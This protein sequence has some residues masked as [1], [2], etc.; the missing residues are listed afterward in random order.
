MLRSNAGKKLVESQLDDWTSEVSTWSMALSL[1]Q[2]EPRNLACLA[3]W[4][5]NGESPRGSYISTHQVHL[6][7]GITGNAP[8]PE[9]ETKL[10]H[11]QE[12]MQLPTH[13]MIWC[14]LFKAT[15]V[16]PASYG[17]VKAPG[18]AAQNATGIKVYIHQAPIIQ[19]QIL[20]ATQAGSTPKSEINSGP[21]RISWILSR[22]PRTS[23]VRT[24]S[25]R[26]R[27]HVTH[28][29]NSSAWK[30]LRRAQSGHEFVILQSARDGYVFSMICI[31][32]V[33]F[34]YVYRNLQVWWYTQMLQFPD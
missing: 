11:H 30:P 28:P 17:L 4:A 32:K 31:L 14:F 33:G 20:K 18:G 13:L 2:S 6:T 23:Q 1:C 34:R 9:D 25:T 26:P 24:R 19:R 5:S 27:L 8:E 29:K 3:C 7:I 22:L 16:Q 21:I 15:C 12:T 10:G